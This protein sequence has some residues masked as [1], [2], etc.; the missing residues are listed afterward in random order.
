MLSFGKFAKMELT[1]HALLSRGYF[2][3]VFLI[4]CSLEDGLI[5]GAQNSNLDLLMTLR[6]EAVKQP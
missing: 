6:M 5:A 2:A 4:S 1:W 3:L